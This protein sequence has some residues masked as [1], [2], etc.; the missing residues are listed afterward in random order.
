MTLAE[1]KSLAMPEAEEG[2]RSSAKVG[3]T[4]VSVGDVVLVV[5]PTPSRDQAD[6][7]RLAEKCLRFAPITALDG[8]AGI[9]LDLTG[10]RRVLDRRG[11]ESGLL[12]RIERSF[13]GAQ[14]HVTTAVADTAVAARAWADC[15]KDADDSGEHLNSRIIPPGRQADFLESLPVECLGFS[16]ETLDGIHEVNV[17]SVGQLQRLPRATL[18]VRYGG[19]VL[20]R[21]DQAMGRLPMVIEPVRPR[22]TVSERV[23]FN[24]PVRSRQAIELAIADL[25]HRVRRRLEDLESGARIV[26]I[27]LERPDLPDWIRGVELSRATRRRE[28]LWMM[29]QPVIERLPLD[30]GVDSVELEIPRHRRLRHEPAMMIAGATD[31][32]RISIRE[33]EADQASFIDLVQ[34]RFGAGSV[35]RAA[36]LSGHVPEDEARI[37]PVD[38]KE[39]RASSSF[40]IG[41]PA[42]A[43]RP[44]VLH[45]PPIPVDVECHGVIPATVVRDEMQWSVDV[46]EGP[47]C[48]G[49]PWWR[50]AGS[51]STGT[52]S[53][54]GRE[55][56]RHYWRLRID[57][58]A[59]IWVFK[60]WSTGRWFLH[61]TWA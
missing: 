20:C 18:P 53:A 58:G 12:D 57:S 39:A 7:R 49:S 50:S 14:L 48:I 36:G 54:T 28:H 40:Q 35:H 24:G 6:L 46:A 8:P 3:K 44:T 31:D 2:S 42:R 1:A 27:R 17:R 38:R 41:P 33:T 52:R 34:S 25:L 56:Q 60:S 15:R 5:P 61:G 43:L 29:L 45:R 4:A 47:E 16:S 21:L 9:L 19:A 51:D 30:H 59:W 55:P 37:E 23:E 10:C 11:G 26:R 32:G 13:N 22:I